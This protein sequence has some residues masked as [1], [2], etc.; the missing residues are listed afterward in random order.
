[1]LLSYATSLTVRTGHK[2][3]LI[4]TA[5]WEKAFEKAVLQAGLLRV[6]QCLTKADLKNGCDRIFKATHPEY[7]AC[8]ARF[9]PND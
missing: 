9:G 1:M 7:D 3:Q 2:L 5:M 6:H 8:A 4:S